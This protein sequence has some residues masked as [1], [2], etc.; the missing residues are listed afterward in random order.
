MAA[1]QVTSLV[2]WFASLVYQLAWVGAV[3]PRMSAVSCVHWA[4]SG[5]PGGSAQALSLLVTQAA[6]DLS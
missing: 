1:L 5:A 4:C 6:F 3:V 2:R